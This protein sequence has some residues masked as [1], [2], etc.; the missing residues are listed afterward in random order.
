MTS[1]TFIVPMVQAGAVG[2]DH[3]G[4]WGWGMGIFGALSMFLVV[5]LI[6]WLIVY[7]VRGEQGRGTGVKR[8]LDLL[9]TRYARGEIDREEY[10][11]RRADLER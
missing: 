5:G 2:W 3:M 4:A 1:F 7:L 8:A 6:V 11:Q 10:L 9:D